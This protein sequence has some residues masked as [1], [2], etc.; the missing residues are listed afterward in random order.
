[1]DL[2]FSKERFTKTVSLGFFVLESLLIITA[3]FPLAYKS[4][5]FTVLFIGNIIAVRFLL[6]GNVGNKTSMFSI[7]LFSISLL[8]FWIN[9]ISGQEEI[10]YGSNNG[11]Y[12]STSSA[13]P[14][15]ATWYRVQI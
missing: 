13:Y 3:L 14:V 7:I 15:T 11:Q 4:P 9:P 8:A 2:N 10:Q 1:M 5:F 12:I 6:G